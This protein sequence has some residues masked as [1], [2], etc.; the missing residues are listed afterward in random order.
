MTQTGL[1]SNF[2]NT[3]GRP[4]RAVTLYYVNYFVTRNLS[5]KF[6]TEHA[7]KQE[8]LIISGIIMCPTPEG[9]VHVIVTM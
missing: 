8:K 5:L 6:S 1:T 4:D 3:Q 9:I 2:V 7:E